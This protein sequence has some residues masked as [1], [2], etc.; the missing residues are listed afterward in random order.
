MNEQA[1]ADEG[2]CVLY[3]AHWDRLV[4]IAWLLLRE[5]TAA[6]DAVQDAF[7]STHRAWDRIR[8]SGAVLAYLHRAVVNNC[9]SVQRHGVVADRHLVRARSD[10]DTAGARPQESA[11]EQALRDLERE[12]MTRRLAAL[13]QRQREVLVLR[14]YA[15]L[16]EAQIAAALEISPGSVKAHA[17]R[18]LASLRSSLLPIDQETTHEGTTHGLTTDAQTTDR[19]LTGGHR[20]DGHPTDGH[21]TDGHPTDGRPTKDTR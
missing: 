13:P 14:Y 2:I 15:D 11:E 3:G 7:V 4:R 9:R 20:S 1:S 18:A 16:S 21:A 19:R 17:H 8:D 5:Q 6:E 12:R 10:P